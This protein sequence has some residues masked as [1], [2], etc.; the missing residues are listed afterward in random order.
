MSQIPKCEFDQCR[1]YKIASLGIS[2]H[3]SG[4]LTTLPSVIQQI[5]VSGVT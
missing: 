5:I 2:R 4:G 3:G 1:G